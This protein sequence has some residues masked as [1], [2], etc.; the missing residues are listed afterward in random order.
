MYLWLKAELVFVARC[1]PL[2]ERYH[3]GQGDKIEGTQVRR[4][5]SI[6]DRTW[7]DGTEFS[8]HLPFALYDPTFRC[9]CGGAY[10]LLSKF[11]AVI[12]APHIILLCVNMLIF[13][14]VSSVL[15]AHVPL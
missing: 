4:Q 1:R 10:A 13:V 5:N 11:A 3:I 14:M 8:L 12:V 6:T 9:D 7:R 2:H 15:L